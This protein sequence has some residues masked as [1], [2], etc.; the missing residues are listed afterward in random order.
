MAELVEARCYN[1]VKQLD[2]LFSAAYIFEM[3]ID[4]MPSVLK[5]V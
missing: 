1:R 4:E 5:P 2:N 3:R